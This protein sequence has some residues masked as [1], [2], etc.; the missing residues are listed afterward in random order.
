MRGKRLNM[1]DEILL[2]IFDEREVSTKE[3]IKI[4]GRTKGASY[5]AIT[6]LKSE[7]LIEHAGYQRYKVTEEG[8]DR[9][10]ELLA[11]RPKINFTPKGVMKDTVDPVETAEVAPEKTIAK[12]VE[13]A[14][15]MGE[16]I[17][18]QVN[19]EKVFKACWEL[20]YISLVNKIVDSALSKDN[21]ARY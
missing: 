9:V 4:T 11:G 17:D 3:V 16:L 5:S 12:E 1:K 21:S 15:V 6:Y 7:G 13:I 20:E 14:E 8:K 18:A 2:M 19:E 10:A